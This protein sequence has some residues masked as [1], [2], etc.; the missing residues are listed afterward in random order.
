MCNQRKGQKKY[1]E[2]CNVWPSSTHQIAV[3]RSFGYDWH[4][5]V[6]TLKIATGYFVH[7]SSCGTDD[8]LHMIIYNAVD[9][10]RS[11]L[12]NKG[13]GWWYD[14]GNTHVWDIYLLS[15]CR[16]DKSSKGSGAGVCPSL[17]SSDVTFGRLWCF[18]VMANECP[19]KFVS[20]KRVPEWSRTK[21]IFHGICSLYNLMTSPTGVLRILT[22]M[23]MSMARWKNVTIQTKLNQT[24]TD[25][26]SRRWAVSYR[27]SSSAADKHHRLEVQAQA[28]PMASNSS[29]RPESDQR[30]GRILECRERF[31]VESGGND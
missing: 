4:P 9:C 25:Y 13:I 24:L 26:S 5:F 14:R 10:R 21:L 20:E 7:G 11:C 19:A 12:S 8:I 31:V 28:L 3:E 16:L 2:I 27:T 22:W 18:A 17:F 29:F 30:V 23:I 6:N 1:W 15:S